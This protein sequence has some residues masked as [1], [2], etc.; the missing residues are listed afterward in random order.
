MIPLD[1]NTSFILTIL[2]KNLVF[3]KVFELKIGE[4]GLKMLDKIIWK[5]ADNSLFLQQMDGL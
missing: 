3:Q 4:F 1:L 2:L 5:I